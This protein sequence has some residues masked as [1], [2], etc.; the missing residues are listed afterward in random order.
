MH[1]LKEEGSQYV[2]RN[3]SGNSSRFLLDLFQTLNFSFLQLKTCVWTFNL[4][5]PHQDDMLVT[6]WKEW[7]L[8]ENATAALYFHD[9]AFKDTNT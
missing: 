6:K 8:L 7:R 4:A 5:C 9:L 1:F 2:L 3:Q